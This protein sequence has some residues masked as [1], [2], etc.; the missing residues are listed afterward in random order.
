ME[1]GFAVTCS[2]SPK[3]SLYAHSR[4]LCAYSVHKRN[5]LSHIYAVPQL[6]ERK[7]KVIV[8][9][10]FGRACGRNPPAGKTIQCWFNQFQVRRNAEK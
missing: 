8:Q 7:S 1:R 2:S 10:N 9:R 6:A 5:T 3:L 4:I